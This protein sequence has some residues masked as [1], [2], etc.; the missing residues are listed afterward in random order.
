MLPPPYMQRRAQPESEDDM[1][2]E[3]L[4]G[5]EDDEEAEMERLKRL[6]AEERKRAI[7][8]ALACMQGYPADGL[9]GGR[10]AHCEHWVPPLGRRRLKNRQSARKVGPGTC[11]RPLYT[12]AVICMWPPGAPAT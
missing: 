12:A 6:P 7:R 11:Y 4:S 8:C 3:G 1:S 10:G 2:D 9:R 5:A